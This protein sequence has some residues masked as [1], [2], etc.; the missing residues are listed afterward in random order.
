MGQVSDVGIGE[1]TR[2]RAANIVSS[3]SEVRDVGKRKTPVRV[4]SGRYSS[5]IKV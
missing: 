4:S 1:Q 5:M 3:V 2:A